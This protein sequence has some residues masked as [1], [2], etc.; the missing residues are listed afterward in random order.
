[1]TGDT[2][3]THSREIASGQRFGFG[4]NWRSFLARLNE[5]RIPGSVPLPGG[6]TARDTLQGRNFLDVG[7]GSGLFSLAAMRLGADEVC[8]FDFDP[9]SVECA[10]EMKRRYHPEDARWRIL[11]GSVLDRAF[12][13]SL[14]RYSVVYSWGVLHHTGAMW[15]ALDNIRSLVAPGGGAV[16]GR[17]LQQPGVEEQGLAWS[18]ET[19]LPNSPHTAGAGLFPGS[20]LF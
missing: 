18:Q 3:S 5:D 15:R 14:G 2:G 8:S 7:S 4:K 9:A 19:V 6:A 20:T 17:D 10:M 12:L 11:E 13:D 16:G 1:M